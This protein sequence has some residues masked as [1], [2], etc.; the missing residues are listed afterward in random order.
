MRKVGFVVG[1][2]TVMMSVSSVHGAYRF[3][4][5]QD[6]FRERVLGDMDVMPT[7]NPTG[8]A[9]L[10]QREALRQQKQALVNEQ[11][12]SLSAQKQARTQ[13]WCEQ[14]ESRINN[15]INMY[16]EKRDLYVSRHQGVVKRLTTLMERLTEKGCEVSNLEPAVEGYEIL[17]DELAAAFRVFVASMQGT[18]VLAC[19]ESEG[20]FASKI[21]ETNVDL[22]DVKV[23]A[24]ALQDYFKSTLQPALTAEGRTCQA[25]SPVPTGMEAK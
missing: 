13:A 7:T 8:T 14:V 2:L 10:E 15:R 19:G 18:R 17:V 16:E 24:Q 9:W 11:K 20:Q 25:V 5:A 12:A 22:Q 1:V 3:E 23:K 4:S 6:K 21:R